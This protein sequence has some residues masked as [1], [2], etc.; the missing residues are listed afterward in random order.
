[1]APSIT[2][3]THRI[4]GRKKDKTRVTFL[5]CVN[6]NSTE[7]FLLLVVGSA[8][9]PHC[10]RGIPFENLG[11]LYGNTGNAWMTT[12]VFFEWLKLF[13][14]YITKTAG[15]K[16]L[17]L[18]DCASCHGVH[19]V[20]PELRSVHLE[21]LPANTTS[22]CQPLDA[23]IIAAIKRRLRKRQYRRLLDFSSAVDPKSL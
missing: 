13:D 18:A 21:F 11:I 5:A 22:L 6:S 20:L 3:G 14:D 19:S 16:V 23:G 8:S 12:S 7:K 10:L 2:I 1:M 15:R 17:L 4:K 9:Q